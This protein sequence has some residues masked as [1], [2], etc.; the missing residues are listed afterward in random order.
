MDELAVEITELKKQIQT[1]KQMWTIMV[2]SIFYTS[3]YVD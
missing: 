1:R 2:Q 3:Q